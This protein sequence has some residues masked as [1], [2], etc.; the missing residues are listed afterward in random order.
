[1]NGEDEAKRKLAELL[2]GTHKKR[3]ELSEEKEPRTVEEALS[4]KQ[5]DERY[6]LDQRGSVKKHHLEEHIRRLL[7][8]FPAELVHVVDE[9]ENFDAAS[10]EVVLAEIAGMIAMIDTSPP[11]GS[12]Y[13]QLPTKDTP[14]DLWGGTWTDVSSEFAGQF[15]RAAGGN[16]AAFGT[17]QADQILEHKHTVPGYDVGLSTFRLNAESYTGSPRVY[18]NTSSV[19]GIENRP[20]NHAI[21]V[22][23]RTA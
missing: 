5:G 21:K 2:K 22:W 16:A 15:F 14:G 20:T 6:L 8:N 9:D 12:I 13:F 23:E 10:L 3:D 1:L 18:A 11:I 17:P 7:E 19:G 4:K